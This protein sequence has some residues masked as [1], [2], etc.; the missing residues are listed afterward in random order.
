M[1][2]RLVLICRSHIYCIFIIYYVNYTSSVEIFYSF[3]L[4]TEC[5]AY[6]RWGRVLVSVVI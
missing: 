6:Y 5:S 3:I 4:V 1:Q 2:Y